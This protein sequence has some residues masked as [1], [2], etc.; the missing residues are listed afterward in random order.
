M[1][2]TKA[3]KLT[4]P[5]KKSVKSSREKGPTVAKAPPKVKPTENRA[6]TVEIKVRQMADDEEPVQ[7]YA[8]FPLR[9]LKAR[10]GYFSEKYASHSDTTAAPETEGA[11]DIVEILPW[12]VDLAAAKCAI[13]WV[14]REDEPDVPP[15]YNETNAYK[16]EPGWK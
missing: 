7:A 10:L 16:S 9:T 11:A 2:T 6:V 4:F 3:P 14:R 8:R 15:Y 12:T 5:G 1:Q 13:R